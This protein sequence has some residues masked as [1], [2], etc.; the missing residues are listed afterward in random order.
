MNS[1]EEYRRRAEECVQLA[2]SA[3]AS[4]RAILIDIAQTWV[5]LADLATTERAW[6]GGDGSNKRDGAQPETS[7]S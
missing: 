5:R 3:P 1:P 7:R 2:Q 4:Q 6:I